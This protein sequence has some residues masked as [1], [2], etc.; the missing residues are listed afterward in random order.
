MTREPSARARVKTATRDLRQML[1]ELDQA[2]RAGDLV[3][4]SELRHCIV[5]EAAEI[6]DAACE[7][8]R[9]LRT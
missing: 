3:T 5:A 1:R 8:E 4:V 7:I 2:I 6:D 9:A